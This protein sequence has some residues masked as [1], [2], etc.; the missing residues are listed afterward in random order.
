MIKNL[1]KTIL[2]IFSLRLN[3]VATRP[4]TLLG[5]KPVFKKKL[6]KDRISDETI[7]EIFDFFENIHP[8]YEGMKI[9]KEL[10]ING[11]WLKILSD[12]RTKQIK[13]LKKQEKDNFKCLLE[14]LF[15]N[16]LNRGVWNYQYYENGKALKT[17]LPDLFID[18]CKIYEKITSLSVGSLASNEYF[19]TWGAETESGI[20]KYPSLNHGIQAFNL[21]NLIESFDSQMIVKVLDLGS[22]YGGMTEYLLRHKT[23]M[24]N[25]FSLTLVDIPLNLT[26]AF[27]YLSR[28]FSKEEF[29]LIKS[30]NDLNALNFDEPKIVLIP[31]CFIES[32]HSNLDI[33]NNYQSFSE[34]DPETVEFY[35]S[36][37]TKRFPK[38]IIENN[39]NV[40]NSENYSNFKE[41]LV[42]NFNF[43]KEYSL[44]SRFSA[45]ESWS[46]YV[47]SIYSNSNKT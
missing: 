22:G 19:D 8:F 2:S 40:T 16:E 7:D 43:P 39:V 26:T 45:P 34:M 42:R 15:F 23:K 4:I 36:T 17:I 3:K 47:T 20:V 14:N 28:T 21:M 5:N 33:V 32:I 31:S 10:E 30:L 38:Y 44:L 25:N 1:I 13:Y 37:L 6:I 9:S 24:K 41:T 27:A 11:A 18:E 46:R 29:I 35:I 12:T